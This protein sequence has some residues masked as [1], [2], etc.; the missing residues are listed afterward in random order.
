MGVSAWKQLWPQMRRV[1]AESVLSFRPLLQ[2][3]DEASHGV[4]CALR[5]VVVAA[6]DAMIPQ[7]SQVIEAISE[8][9]RSAPQ[10]ALLDA[11]AAVVQAHIG[12]SNLELLNV[13][14]QLLAEVSQSLLDLCRRDGVIPHCILICSLCSALAMVAKEFPAAVFRPSVLAL[15]IIRFSIDIIK[16]PDLLASLPAHYEALL[17]A[18]DSLS[19]LL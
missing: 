17:S 10:S 3:K 9:M 6:R 8:G 4:V 7:L 14:M 5:G 19:V 11:V 1:L 15:A 2:F 13:V 12:S 16:S 18:V